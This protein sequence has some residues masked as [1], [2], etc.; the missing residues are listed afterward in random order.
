LEEKMKKALAVILT[1][2]LVLSV[3]VACRKD[4]APRSPAPGAAATGTIMQSGTIRIITPFGVGGTH[5]ATTRRF[6]HVANR[7][8]PQ[9][10]FIIDNMT[11]GDGFLGADYFASL[12]PNTTDLFKLSYG[13]VFR[14]DI[15]RAHGTEVVVFDRHAIQPVAVIDDRTWIAYALPGTTVEDI[16]RL[17]RSGQVRMSGGNPLSDPHLAFA[18][19]IIA[20]GGRSIVIPYDG[21]AMQR[22]ALI[23]KEVDVF[24]GSTQAGVEEV[25]AGL[26]VPILA[27]S[28]VAFDGF[29]TP[30][31][32]IVVPPVTGANR[33]PTLTREHPDSVLPGG[34]MI[35]VRRGAP[36]EWVDLHIRIARAVWADPEYHQWIGEI[37]LN[38]L[39]LY[40]ADVENRV[41]RGVERAMAAF[42]ILAAGR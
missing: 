18:S 22:Q 6:A 5:D 20:E 15:G 2:V 25:R 8:F 31:G 7:L 23:N 39:E 40:G 42:D 41:E 33:H 28:D 17:S 36:Q 21:G 9:Y 26:I 12:P 4:P 10:N 27:I 1:L 35:S 30:G 3:I 37:M 16:L 24:I 38:R 11:G 19:L 32:P 34:G 29:V 14:H 13:I